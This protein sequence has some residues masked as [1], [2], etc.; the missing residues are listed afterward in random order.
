MICEHQ[1]SRKR[2]LYV[3]N[4]PTYKIAR[5]PPFTQVCIVP[6]ALNC[7]ELVGRALVCEVLLAMECVCVKNVTHEN[8]LLSCTTS[9]A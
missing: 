3:S 1:E 9:V 7:P 6:G 4:C 2:T 5:A 8:P